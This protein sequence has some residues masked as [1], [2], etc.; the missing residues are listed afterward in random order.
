MP[1]KEK[2]KKILEKY[3]L[4]SIREGGLEYLVATNLMILEQLKKLTAK[5]KQIIETAMD[6]VLKT[7][8]TLIYTL[9]EKEKKQLYQLLSKLIQSQNE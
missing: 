6:E 9:T 8:N 3:G 1:N 4:P 7:E 2:F 5:G